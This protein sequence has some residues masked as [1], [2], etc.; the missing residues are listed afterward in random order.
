MAYANIE[1]LW[2]PTRKVQNTSHASYRACH[3]EFTHKRVLFIFEKSNIA[4]LAN[5]QEIFNHGRL[6]NRLAV[7]R[8]WN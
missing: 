8:Y 6:K 7:L 2:Y 1:Q 5:C 3:G 4:H